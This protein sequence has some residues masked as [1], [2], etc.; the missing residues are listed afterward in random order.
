L[1]KVGGAMMH[2]TIL[3]DYRTWQVFPLRCNCLR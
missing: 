2:N 1:N 3:H